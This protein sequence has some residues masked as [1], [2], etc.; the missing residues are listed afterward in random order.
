MSEE[1]VQRLASMS[2]QEI[3]NIDMGERVTPEEKDA[4]LHELYIR[5]TMLTAKRNNL[6]RRRLIKNLRTVS[7]P[8][9]LPRQ[10]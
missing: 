2:H 7:E 3:L 8:A 6:L 1:F 5:I 4:M 10:R 9:R